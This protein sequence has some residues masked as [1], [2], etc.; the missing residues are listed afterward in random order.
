MIMISSYGE[1]SQQAID[2]I[3]VLLA[4]EAELSGQSKI[5]PSFHPSG[6]WWSLEYFFTCDNPAMRY[7]H[8]HA[9]A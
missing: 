3:G 9:Q 2:S 5:F 6:R 8:F 1:Q 7:Y 4:Q